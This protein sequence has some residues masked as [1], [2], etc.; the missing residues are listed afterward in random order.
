MKTFNIDFYKNKKIFFIISIA[1]IVIGLIC[2][3]IFGAQLDI[4]FAGGA[5]IKYSVDG[6]VDSNEIDSLVEKATGRSV[7]VATSEIF[8]SS[9]KQITVSF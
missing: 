2:N 9:D 6:D 3:V 4:Q 8:G 5:M 7:S 1:V